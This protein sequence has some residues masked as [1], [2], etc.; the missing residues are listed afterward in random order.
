[1]STYGVWPKVPPSL[2]TEQLE[3]REKFMMRWHQE[4][5]TKYKMLENFNHG[6]PAGLEVKPGSVTL[7]IG[8]GIGEHSRFENLAIQDYHCLE[9]REAFCIELRKLFKENRVFS[10]DIH[11]RQEQW[12]DGYFD[13][14]IAIHVLEHLVNLP[15]ALEEICRLMKTNAVFDVVLPTEG[16]LAYS[17]ARKI[18]AQRLFESNFKMDY[19]PIIKNEHVSVFTEIIDAIQERFTIVHQRYF[20]LMV[21]VSDL[22]LCVGLRL[23]KK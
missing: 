12:A 3:A 21:P 17:L 8:A 22:N 9:Y 15:K 23:K 7:E 13:R 6:Y 10:G 14:V 20:P 19:T 4:L 2:S 18:S 5:P 16:G 1:M 11:K